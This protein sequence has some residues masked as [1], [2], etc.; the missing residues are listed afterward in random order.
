MFMDVFQKKYRWKCWKNRWGNIQWS[1]LPA[2]VVNTVRTEMTPRNVLASA[3]TWLEPK[4]AK[5]N[6]YFGHLF[7]QTSSRMQQWKLKLHWQVM[8]LGSKMA[9]RIGKAKLAMDW[10]RNHRTLRRYAPGNGK[11]PW[12]CSFLPTSSK[13][14]C[15]ARSTGDPR[16]FNQKLF[17]AFFGHLFLQGERLSAADQF[18]IGN[19][20]LGVFRTPWPITKNSRSNAGSWKGTNSK[21]IGVVVVS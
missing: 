7:S 18:W 16:L 13:M 9:G 19:W 2:V 5:C 14:S 6:S 17:E 20:S 3:W 4:S 10:W 21:Y 15:F 8:A 1:D 11:S 12:W